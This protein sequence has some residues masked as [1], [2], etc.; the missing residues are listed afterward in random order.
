M[1]K[2]NKTSYVRAKRPAKLR[3]PAAAKRR[4]SNG[5]SRIGNFFLPFFLSFCILVCLG[6]LGFLG[7]RNV[8][9][10]GFFDVKA[11][12]IQG[13]ERASKQDIERTVRNQTERSGAW[14]ADLAEIKEKVEKMQFVKTAAVSRVLPSEI[15]VSVI[16][17]I[18]TAIVRLKSGDVLVD[19]EA[20]ILAPA[21]VKENKLPFTMIG[22]DETKTEKAVKDNLDR[23]KIYAKMLE[24]WKQ[25][26]L[27]S[28]V[29]SVDLTDLREARA[30]TEDSGLDVSIALGKDNFG[31]NL[32]KGINAIVG[33]GE[34]FEAVDL[35]GQ[36]MILSPRK[37][38]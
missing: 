14:N 35:V 30:I 5:P 12:E 27:A 4:T 16:E 24:E 18:P 22:W 33:K 28:R 3:R 17:R 2:Q 7:Y 34:I 26:D 6:V 29:R 13:V 1:Q 38:Q 9:A 23:V 36:N 8:T 10:S 11:I 15:R 19:N 20:R 31:E 25:F 37:A 32:K 21:D